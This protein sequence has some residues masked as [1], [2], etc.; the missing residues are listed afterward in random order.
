MRP[1]WVLVV[2]DIFP[3]NCLHNLLY[4]FGEDECG[5]RACE[6]PLADFATI[7]ENKIGK[8][9]QFANTFVI[10]FPSSLIKNSSR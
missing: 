7:L 1:D 9:R 2:L 10:L 3:P 5:L 8:V 4:T 6:F